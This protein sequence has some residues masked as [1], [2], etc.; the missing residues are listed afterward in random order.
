MGTKINKKRKVPSSFVKKYRICHCFSLG[1]AEKPFQLKLFIHFFYVCFPHDR[2]G[3]QGVST[4]PSM[5]RGDTKL[6]QHTRILLETPL[7]TGEMGVFN[8]HATYTNIHYSPYN[9]HATY[10]AK[11]AT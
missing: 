9:I 6:T 7:D 10:T 4:I 3:D 5:R 8:I 1:G 2:S 11:D